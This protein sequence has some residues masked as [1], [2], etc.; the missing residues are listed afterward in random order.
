MPAYKLIKHLG[1]LSLLIIMGI[2]AW[3]LMHL[4]AKIS[5][6][7]YGYLSNLKPELV[8]SSQIEGQ[9]IDSEGWANIL[10]IRSSIPEQANMII[11]ELNNGRKFNNLQW[12]SLSKQKINEVQYRKYILLRYPLYQPKRYIFPVI[13]AF[14]YQDSFA[15]SREGGK[16]QHEGTDIFG[17]EGTLI[18]SVSAGKIE[19]IGWNR[20]GGERV[21]VRGD[22][23]NYYYYAHLQ[24]IASELHKGDKVDKGTKLGTMGHTGDAVTTPDHLHFGIQLP[25]GTWINPYRFLKVWENSMKMMT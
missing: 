12:G 16:R 15:A 2:F 6:D 8:I 9:G 19:Q 21:G 7:I 4:Q 14:W 20:L 22:D 23:G 1:Q 11:S 25:D 13:G 5:P 3:R 10:A 24:T 18:I 17:K